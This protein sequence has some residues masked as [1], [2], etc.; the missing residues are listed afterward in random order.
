MVPLFCGSREMGVAQIQ[1]E[2]QTAGVGLRFHLPGFHFG[3]NCLS[4][5]Q[6]TGKPLLW[7]DEILHHWYLQGTHHSRVSLVVQDFG[8]PQYFGGSNWLKL[9]EAELELAEARAAAAEAK[10]ALAAAKSGG[11]GE[12]A[13]Q[14]EG[15]RFCGSKPFAPGEHHRW[16]MEFGHA[17][18]MPIPFWGG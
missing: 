1:P 7:M 3:T 17:S 18:P 15:I 16:Q 14:G 13:A 9:S 2:G 6:M 11:E 5:S 10:A 8:H 12:G 4:H